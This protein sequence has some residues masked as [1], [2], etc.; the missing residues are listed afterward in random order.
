[1]QAPT[2]SSAR[3]SRTGLEPPQHLAELLLE[4]LKFDDLLPYRAQLLD[5]DV[6]EPRT[7]RGA[8]LVLK[9]GRQYS[10]SGEGKP[11]RASAANEEEPID[12]ACRVLTVS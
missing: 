10:E 11:Q 4:Q 3:C 5:H 6:Q 7:Q 12:I 9:L 2:P 8:P 1:M